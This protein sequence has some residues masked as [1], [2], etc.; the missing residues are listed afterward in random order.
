M[1]IL[2]ILILWIDKCALLTHF[3]QMF[4]FQTTRKMGYSRVIT[5]AHWLFAKSEISFKINS[6]LTNTS[7][8]Y[9]LK[10]QKSNGLEEVWNINSLFGINMQ[11]NSETKWGSTPKIFP[12]TNLTLRRYL[13]IYIHLIHLTFLKKIYIYIFFLKTQ[14]H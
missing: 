13:R 9:P 1:V 6:F 4:S 2:E 7:I 11:W 10:Y 3:W 8:F 12:Q 5:S 14:K